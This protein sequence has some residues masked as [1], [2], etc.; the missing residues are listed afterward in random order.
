MEEYTKQFAIRAE[1]YLEKMGRMKEIFS[2]IEMPE[3]FINEMTAQV[4]RLEKAMKE[5]G[6]VISPLKFK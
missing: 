2:K 1:K 6:K 3:E 4:Q 5:H